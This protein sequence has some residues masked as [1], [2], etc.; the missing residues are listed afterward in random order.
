MSV[1][2]R[3]RRFSRARL[4]RISRVYIAASREAAFGTFLLAEQ[5][6]TRALSRDDDDENDNN[7]NSNV[8][9]W[10]IRVCA[11]VVESIEFSKFGRFLEVSQSS[12]SVIL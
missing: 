4:P 12:S 11:G 1:R 2:E 9:L 5:R 8:V 7:Q 10:K 3:R 6:Y